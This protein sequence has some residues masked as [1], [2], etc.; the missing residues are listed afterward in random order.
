MKQRCKTCCKCKEE[1][2]VD[3][4]YSMRRGKYGVGTICKPCASAYAK[5]RVRPRMLL[6]KYGMTLVDYQNLL[7]S[8]GGVCAICGSEK[9]CADRPLAVDHCH[10]TGVV[11]GLL[12]SSCN[13]GLGYFRD[14]PNRLEAAVRYLV[15]RS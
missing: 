2:P 8:Q 3:Q 11:R 14:D 12:C 15:T 10:D 9:S 7:E 5:P 4:F 13:S 6:I 1:K